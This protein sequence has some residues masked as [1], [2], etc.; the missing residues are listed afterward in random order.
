MPTVSLD[1]EAY[2]I[3]FNIRNNMKHQS[4]AQNGGELNFTFS[5]AVKSL[6]KEADK[7]K[8]LLE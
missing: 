5:D 7:D 1:K 2:M 8:E 3:L 4:I 6:K